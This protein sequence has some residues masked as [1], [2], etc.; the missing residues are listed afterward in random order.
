MTYCKIKEVSPGVLRFEG[1]DFTLNMSYNAKVV[2]PKIEY[3]EVKDNSLHR[4]WPNGVSRIVFQFIK[5]GTSGS[6]E[7]IFTAAKI[8][9]LETYFQKSSFYTALFF[10][11]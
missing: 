5:P 10:S 7:L 6:S 11:A 2:K 9:S 3:Y 4:Y 1:E 8:N